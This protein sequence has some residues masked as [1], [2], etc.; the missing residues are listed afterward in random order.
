MTD[1][2]DF[3]AAWGVPYF[4]CPECGK[5]ANFECSCGYVP[6]AEFREEIDK[7]K[8]AIL[9]GRYPEGGFNDA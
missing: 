9:S 8:R 1:K 2:D 7:R 4:V 6:T 3:E 5:V